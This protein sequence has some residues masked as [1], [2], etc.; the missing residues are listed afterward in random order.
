MSKLSSESISQALVIFII[1]NQISQSGDIQNFA[2]ILMKNGPMTL[3]Q[4]NKIMGSS[5]ENK[6]FV[7]E[8]LSIF[9]KHDIVKSKFD[10]SEWAYVYTF[11]KN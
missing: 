1:E 10:N 6:K 2:S 9:I 11:D 5:R 7:A 4:I 8:A 3:V